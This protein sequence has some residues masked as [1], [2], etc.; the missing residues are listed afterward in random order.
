MTVL[1]FTFVLVIGNVLK[2]VL[3]LMVNGQAPLPVVLKAIGLL[4]PIA[5]SYALPMGMLTAVLLVFGRFSADL[6][7]TA[8]RAGGVSLVS[9]SAPILAL[10][11]VLCGLS[12]WANMDL[13]PNSKIGYRQ[14]FL[15]SWASFGPKQ[16]AAQLPEG[17]HF[18]DLRSDVVLYIG[19]NNDGDLR[20]VL[21][22][23]RDSATN[24]PTTIFARRAYIEKAEGTNRLFHLK[25]YEAEVIS[26]TDGQATIAVSSDTVI[27][28]DPAVLS[29][30]RDNVVSIRNMSFRQLLA[31]LKN[32]DVRG[33]EESAIPVGPESKRRME[34]RK[35]A[36]QVQ[37]HRQLAFS[38]ACFGF[39]LV[40]IPLGI[41]VQ[42]RETNIGF[43]M[44]IILVLVYYSLILLGLS[45]DGKPQL[46]PHLVLW[47]PNLVFQ[48]VGAILLW[49]AN[50]GL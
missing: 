22:I 48:G 49:R 38:F 10:S 8:A 35:G 20:D 46:Y 3:G 33:N 16:L 2:E 50:R 32:V 23:R 1:V 37:I 27:D 40:G 43:A 5:I 47:L 24:Q 13:A 21:V 7:L 34:L 25:L 19:K 17:R 36:I 11:L 29:R 4:A 14:L 39:T 45:L 26:M 41:R 18:N 12:A 6:E 15:K 9:L 28:F 30:D 44:A 31:E 42:R